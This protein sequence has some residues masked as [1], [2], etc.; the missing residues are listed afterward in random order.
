VS[1]FF[2]KMKAFGDD[3]AAAGRK[4]DDEELIEY[5]QGF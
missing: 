5:K 2:R 4:L 3:M 1:E